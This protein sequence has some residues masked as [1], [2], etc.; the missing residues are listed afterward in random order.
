MKPSLFL[1]AAALLL[2]G[3]ALSLTPAGAS[4][5]PLKIG[6]SAGPYGEILTF[7]ATLA[8]E[9]GLAVEVI[10]F[11]EWTQINE[12]V[13]SGDLDANNFQHLPYL[14]NQKAAR[15]YD[16]VPLEPSIV[17]PIGVYSEK[18]GSLEA[19][20]EG[21]QIGIPNDPTNAARALFLLA[22][23]GVIALRE[24][25]GVDATLADI[26]ENPK[27][28]QFLEIDAAQLPRSLP[29]VAASVITLNYAVLSG[30]DPKQ[31]LALEQEDSQWTLV[32]AARADR[33]EDP[34]LQ[35]FIQLYRSAPVRDFVLTR[36]DGTILPTW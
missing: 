11:T 34:R 15:G 30:L 24:G 12:A 9:E 36:F 19:L 21:G 8:A 10:E 18:L 27:N 35:R 7:A 32:F 22:D 2:A 31:A 20:P 6:V 4:E 5:A 23:S 26:A 14:D 17:V 28:L 16:I 1:R 3:A 29:D 13:Q 25:A 33:A